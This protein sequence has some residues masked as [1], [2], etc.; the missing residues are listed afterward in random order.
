MTRVQNGDYL[1]F[2]VITAALGTGNK[3]PVT[4]RS[5]TEKDAFSPEGVGPVAPVRTCL[6]PSE[7]YAFRSKQKVGTCVEGK[8]RE[9]PLRA[10]NSSQSAKL[11]AGV[12]FYA[13]KAV[14]EALFT[15]RVEQ[16]GAPAAHNGDH[17]KDSLRLELGC[18]SLRPIPG[19]MVNGLHRIHPF[20]GL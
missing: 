4:S 2:S 5:G 13:K 17:W 18:A 6:P 11:C 7:T 8:C 16:K 3:K 19:T 12:T 20:V 15:P 10:P 1:G 14:K 9:S